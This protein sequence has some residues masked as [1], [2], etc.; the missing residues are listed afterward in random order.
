MNSDTRTKS[1]E[2]LD[3]YGKALA[4]DGELCWIPPDKESPHAGGDRLRVAL[5]MKDY[6]GN[7]MGALC[8]WIR[9]DSLYSQIQ[10]INSG[11]KGFT[12]VVNEKGDLIS[13]STFTSAVSTYFDQRYLAERLP[14]L[15]E[16]QDLSIDG[17]NYQIGLVDVCMQEYA[18]MTQAMREC[19][20]GMYRVAAGEQAAW[21]RVP[22][23]IEPIH[24]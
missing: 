6:R 21:D 9:N 10:D 23:D 12:A 3:W 17:E 13:S 15:T 14:D 2:G 20:E 11:D 18:D 24:Y 4:S 22:E 19:H 8:V 16:L 5:L 7:I 1:G